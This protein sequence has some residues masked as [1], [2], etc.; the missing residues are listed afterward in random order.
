METAYKSIS[1]KIAVGILL[2]FPLLACE[3]HASPL[4]EALQGSFARPDVP[5]LPLVGSI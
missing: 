4:L 5:D 3:S 1:V 2:A